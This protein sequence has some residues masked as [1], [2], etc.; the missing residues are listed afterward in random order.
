MA[1]CSQVSSLLQAYIDGELGHAEKSILEQHLRDCPSCRHELGEQNA[2]SAKIFESLSNQRLHGSLR[3][4][5]LA[6]L[7]EMDPAPRLGSHPTDPQ[8]ARRRPRPAAFPRVLLVAAAAILTM[9]G[10]YFYGNETAPPVSRQ[11]AA[12]M[13]TFSDGKEVFRKGANEETYLA[14][15][16]KSLVRVGD[17]YETL[18]GG[19][20]AFSLIS[21]SV[22]KAYYNTG[23]TV[24]DNRRITVEQ[25]LTFFDVGRDKR[26][27]N[28][29]TPGGEILVFGTAFVVEVANNATKVTVTEGDI[30]VS[31]DLGK[32]GV[33][34]GNQLVFRMG[35]PLAK[36]Y[37]VN[38]AEVAAWAD[39]IVPDPEAVALFKQ[40]LESRETLTNAI[41]AIPVYAVWELSSR[42]VS[43]IQIS[44]TPDGRTSGHCGYIVHVA[45]NK[46]NLLYIDTL[47]SS[48]FNDANQQKATLPL[49][50]GPVTGIDGLHIKLV[51]DHREGTI[52]TEMRVDVV[53]PPILQD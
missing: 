28:V 2:C 10:V 3:S 50:G 52:E 40:T 16:L 24:E 45:D 12:G 4:R 22:V 19:R 15:E 51:P 32:T 37:P 36:P 38:V 7:P 47:D 42:Q 21:N 26:L 33:S 43:E 11:P 6:H 23:F 31:N 46:G 41:P 25:G 30:L 49:P 13:V 1:S 29:K 53:A 39:D 35:E 34:K 5:V 14:A 27:F 8:Y 48:L 44:W 20:L 9:A 17:E 18:K